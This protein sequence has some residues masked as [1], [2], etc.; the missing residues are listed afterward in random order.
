M[1]QGLSTKSLEM[2]PMSIL[3]IQLRP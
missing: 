3:G 1:E 2:E